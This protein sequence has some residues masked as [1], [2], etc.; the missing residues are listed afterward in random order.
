M[1]TLITSYSFD[2]ANKK[3]TFLDLLFVEQSRV[4]LITNITDNVIIYNFADPLKGGTTANNVLTLTYNT[5]SMS[6]SDSC[7]FIMICSRKLKQQ[8]T[9][10]N[11]IQ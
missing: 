8:I 11:L 10:F 7:R 1:K 4:L 2:A 6:N 3:V 9:G 5:V